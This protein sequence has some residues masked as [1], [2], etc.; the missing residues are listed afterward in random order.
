[1]HESAIA[2]A[3]VEQAVEAAAA[4]GVERITAIELEVGLLQQ[5]V[6]EALETA[7]EFAAADTPAEG[8]VLHLT[9]RRPEAVCRSCGH[10]FEPSLER[11]SFLC[12]VCQ[13]ADIEIIAGN[14]ITLL[15]LTCD[16][17]SP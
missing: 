1:M 2:S 5:V 7:F 15:S 16:E 13:Q 9:Q 17:K 12:P 4:H 10:R 11:F 14:E 6:P 8:A 3:I